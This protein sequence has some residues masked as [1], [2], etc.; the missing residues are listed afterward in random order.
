M[1]LSNLQIKITNFK[2]IKETDWISLDGK[3]EILGKNFIDGGSNGSGKSSILEALYTIVSLC[4]V[5]ANTDEQK[6]LKK[7]YRDNK[8]PFEILVK[9][10]I[11]Y[12]DYHIT[13]TPEGIKE[14]TIEAKKHLYTLI[15]SF[16]MQGMS[17]SLIKQEASQV[18][19]VISSYFECEEIIDNIIKN[20]EIVKQQLE[21]KLA[22]L[23]DEKVDFENKKIKTENNLENNNTE[24]DRLK[25]EK[26]EI[27]N[28]IG[29]SSFIP[30]D[31][32]IH[33]NLRNEIEELSIK[34]KV[35]GSEI[36][37]LYE[38][39]TEL[40]N[41]IESKIKGLK[42]KKISILETAESLYVRTIGNKFSSYVKKAIK[43]FNDLQK[44]DYEKKNKTAQENK[45]LR[46]K[47]IQDKI[48][49]LESLNSK[50]AYISENQRK[51]I[52]SRSDKYTTLI[53]HE[54]EI[55]MMKEETK[56]LCSDLLDIVKSSE[57]ETIEKLVKELSTIKK[58]SV[59]KF[60]ETEVSIYTLK[61]KPKRNLPSYY[62]VYNWDIETNTRT[63]I[64]NTAT[65]IDPIKLNSSLQ[66]IE[67]YQIPNT[68]D[69]DKEIEKLENTD[70]SKRLKEVASDITKKQELIIDFEKKLNES[71][72]KE[73]H[74]NE[75]KIKSE[76]FQE[77]NKKLLRI[78]SDIEERNL[79][80]FEL[81]KKQIENTLRLSKISE[82]IDRWEQFLEN[83]NNDT[84]L[85]KNSFKDFIIDLYNDRL[86]PL[87]EFYSNKVFNLNS[88]L[89]VK[90]GSKTKQPSLNGIKFDFTSGGE[91]SKALFIFSLAHRDYLSKQRGFNNNYIFC[92][93]VFDGMDEISRQQSI[94]F[95]TQ[96][97]VMENVLV[98]SHME[99]TTLPHFKRIIVT[100]NEN[101]TLINQLNNF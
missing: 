34:V 30:Y 14:G 84:R 68:T 55:K 78:D 61:N 38:E 35:L 70:T 76:L 22:T 28:K 66:E 21:S 6:L 42:E 16:L 95:L 79:S 60:S 93:E 26:T 5:S 67:N 13:A 73:K 62:I 41:G 94:Q 9:F 92:D 43:E 87:I 18:K 85:V 8:Y 83:I 1:T 49:E 63:I 65:I 10:K 50:K 100:K 90:I 97:L 82:Q 37:T 71:R 36:T 51:N 3:I 7:Y 53:S 91:K 2:S 33:E 75:N 27:Q 86:E 81:E 19:S 23:K 11:G 47:E 64:E 39:K 45:E 98:I 54:L 12:E 72:E 32:N 57:S 77:E 48:I 25:N 20:S 96:G 40:A 99:D 101:G 89:I 17:N 59:K 46:I 74:L 31:K 4:E 52:L 80:L 69:L 44:K 24:L 58:S 56:Q 88:K 29:F 15:T